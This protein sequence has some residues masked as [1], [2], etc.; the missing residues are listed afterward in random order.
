MWGRPALLSMC[1]YALWFN[2]VCYMFGSNL[3]T[4]FSQMFYT[5]SSTTMTVQYSCVIQCRTWTRGRTQEENHYFIRF[6][7]NRDLAN[8]LFSNFV[9]FFHCWW[10]HNMHAVSEPCRRRGC[11]DKNIIL[12][13]CQNHISNVPIFLKFCTKVHCLRQCNSQIVSEPSPILRWLKRKNNL[14]ISKH[15]YIFLVEI[16]YLTNRYYSN[17]AHKLFTINSSVPYQKQGPGMKFC[18]MFLIEITHLKNPFYSNFAYKFIVD[19]N[20]DS[21]H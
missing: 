5:S 14:K 20:V 8:R 15:S 4:D 3:A 12:R 10:Q 2:F 16:K 1:L 7:W 13:F 21:I 11:R 18:C 19:D 17:F 6:C 9:Y